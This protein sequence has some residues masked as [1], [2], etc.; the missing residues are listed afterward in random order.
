[1]TIRVMTA[2][3]YLAH[4]AAAHLA[5][6]VLTE[7]RT[8]LDQEC[9]RLGFDV[10]QVMIDAMLAHGA[11]VPALDTRKPEERAR[12]I[13]TTVLGRA[14]RRYEPPAVVRTID[15]LHPTGKCTCAGGGT[16]AWCRWRRGWVE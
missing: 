8:L 12:A 4:L 14:K 3:E 5:N 7:L 15:P 16:C 10:E 2:S 1:M 9:N 13:A 11:F 6:P